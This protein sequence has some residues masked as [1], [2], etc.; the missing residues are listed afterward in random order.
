MLYL[1]KSD[2]T[3]DLDWSLPNSY[4]CDE[5]THWLINVIWFETG[6]D[7]SQEIVL[8]ISFSCLFPVLS[9]TKLYNE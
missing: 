6:Y 3:L 5:Y 7:H 1:G 9:K 8:L 2:L 4:W